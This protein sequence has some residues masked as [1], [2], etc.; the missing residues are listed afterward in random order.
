MHIALFKVCRTPALHVSLIARI[1]PSSCPGSKFKRLFGL[2]CGI[3]AAS[4][5]FVRRG[6]FLFRHGGLDLTAC[7]T[8]RSTWRTSRL[9]RPRV[10]ASASSRHAM[11]K[12]DV[13]RAVMRGYA[14]L[15]L[16][17]RRTGSFV[18][19]TVSEVC[20]CL[21]GKQGPKTVILNIR[22]RSSAS[23]RHCFPSAP[24]WRRW[25]SLRLLERASC[26]HCDHAARQPLSYSLKRDLLQAGL[27]QAP[28]C[29]WPLSLRAWP[30]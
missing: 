1:V 12:H 2:H 23:C 15:N 27:S 13:M 3:S 26:Q 9:A 7:V 24:S 10:V 20:R 6:M 5:K 8:F 19:S 18:R 28:M 4:R 21:K 17:T 22:L 14:R 11:F 30:Q 25:L 29:R 16:C